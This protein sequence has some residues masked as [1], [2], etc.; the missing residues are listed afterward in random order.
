VPDGR[1]QSPFYDKGDTSSPAL[2]QDGF[3][4]S[5]AIDAQEKRYIITA[6]IVGAFLKAKQE[7]FVLV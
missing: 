6:D 1:K 4:A 7:D 2:T 3:F 5:L